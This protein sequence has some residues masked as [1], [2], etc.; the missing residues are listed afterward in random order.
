MK[1]KEKPIPGYNGRYR[2]NSEGHVFSHVHQ[3]KKTGEINR[4]RLKPS[5]NNSGYHGVCL[6][7]DGLGKRNRKHHGVHILVAMA[8]LRRAPQDVEVNHRN[9]KKT[10]NNVRNLEWCTHSENERHAIKM[11]LKGKKK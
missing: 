5:L 9:G 1:I 4:K 2:V 11:G 6:Y 3:D 8:F 10:D 7:L